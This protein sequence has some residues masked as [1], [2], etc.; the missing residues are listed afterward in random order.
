MRILEN[1]FSITIWQYDISGHHHLMRELH[2][3]PFNQ[4][5]GSNFAYW[6]TDWQDSHLTKPPSWLVWPRSNIASR[7]LLNYHESIPITKK[8]I[9]VYMASN[10]VW[11]LNVFTTFVASPPACTE[12]STLIGRAPSRLGSDWLRSLCHKVRAQGTKRTRGTRD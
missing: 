11:S 12:W 2:E 4:W 10:I 1:I 5:E 8:N 7:C 3:N 9:L 6:V